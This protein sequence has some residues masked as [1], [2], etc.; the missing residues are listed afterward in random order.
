M[1]HETT[2]ESEVVTIERPRRL[3]LVGETRGMQYEL[4]HVIGRIDAD[5]PLLRSNDR[6][7]A[8]VTVQPEMVAR[9]M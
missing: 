1:G 7:G 6:E 8:S 9:R 3:R 5:R 4:D 2:D